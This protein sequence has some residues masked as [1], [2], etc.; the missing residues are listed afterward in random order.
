MNDGKEELILLPISEY[1]GVDRDDPIRFYRNPIFGKYYR[2]RVSMCLQQC[3]GGERILEVGFGTGVTFLNLARKYKQIYGLDLKADIAEIEAMFA[4]KG[5]KIN[6]EQGNVLDLPY[7]DEYFDSVLLIS[8]LEHLT[9]KELPRAF[10]EIRRVLMPEG[11]LVYGVPVENRITQAG[12]YLLGY[13][14]RNHH[15]S[16]NQQVRDCASSIMNREEIRHLRLPI[17]GANIY[18]VVSFK[19]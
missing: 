11:Q 1:V 3:K 12:F 17:I 16:T 18:E 10:G 9:P 6:L 19:K 14:I 2:E 5:V 15:F 13:N 8:I 4:T 7:P